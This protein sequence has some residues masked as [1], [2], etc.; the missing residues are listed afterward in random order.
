LS[1]AFTSRIIEGLVKPQSSLLPPAEVSTPGRGASRAV[2]N[3]EQSGTSPLWRI[4]LAYDSWIVRTYVWG[5]FGIMRQRFLDEIG[6]YLPSHGRVL[7][8]G[9]GFGLFSLYYAS[10]RPGLHLRGFD[11]NGNRILTAR[12]A[13]RQLDIL[14]VDYDIGDA[15][16]YRP[17]ERFDAA[18]MLDLV[19]HISESAAE[20]LLRAVAESLNPGGVLLVKDVDTRP[21]YKRVFTRV[22]DLLMDPHAPVHYWPAAKLQALLE[23]LGFRVYR[24]KMIDVLPYPHVLFICRKPEEA[25]SHSS[26]TSPG[27]GS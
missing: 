10:T 24:H 23:S 11:L 15:R 18:Y 5:R 20:P 27:F 22:L 2:P 16:E 19:H 8:I 1:A 4:C 26:P 12:N 25:K 9:C 13:A 7:D 14:N 17:D 3:V 21:A 6:Q